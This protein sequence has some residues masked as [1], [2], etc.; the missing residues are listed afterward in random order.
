MKSLSKKLVSFAILSLFL[1]QADMALAVNPLPR[2]IAITVLCNNAN[3]LHAGNDIREHYPHLAPG[4]IALG[5]LTST[6]DEECRT[7]SFY[8]HAYFGYG[9]FTIFKDDEQI[10]TYSHMFRSGD[11]KTFDLST[12]GP[13][14][15]EVVLENE[16]IRGTGSFTAEDDE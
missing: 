7:L 16:T 1:V 6:F 2:R 10:I 11:H 9:T 4:I 8:F 3:H 15:Y 13:G 5:N 12:Y 14:D